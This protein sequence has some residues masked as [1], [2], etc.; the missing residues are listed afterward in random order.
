MGEM[1]RGGG[2]DFSI[3]PHFPPCIHPIPPFSPIVL[4]S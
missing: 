3:S 4:P 1:G 2:G